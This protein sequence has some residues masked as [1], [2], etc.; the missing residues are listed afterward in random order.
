MDN[1]INYDCEIIHKEIVDKVEKEMLNDASFNKLSNLYK[2]YSD[3]TRIKILFAL[4]CN[5]MCVC[6]LAVLLNMTKSAISHQL[7]FLRSV[8]LVNNR[9]DG[10]IVF[11]SLADNCVKDILDQGLKHINE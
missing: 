1:M 3:P 7:S 5:E 10:K 2:I 6:D 9:K 4:E 11:Y 8:N